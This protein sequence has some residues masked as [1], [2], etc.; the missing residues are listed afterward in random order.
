MPAISEH[1]LVVGLGIIE[2]DVDDVALDIEYGN[3]AGI[4]ESLVGSDV[5]TLVA[6]ENL[7]METEIDVH[8]VGLHHFSRRLIIALALYSLNLGKKSGKLMS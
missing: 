7:G 4:E 8:P 1:L 6:T 5:Q 2:G 3:H